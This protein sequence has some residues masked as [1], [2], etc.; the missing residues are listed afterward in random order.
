MRQIS[1]GKI[2]L[3][4]WLPFLYAAFVFLSDM[5]DKL[6]K[7]LNKQSIR[8]LLFGIGEAVVG[9]IVYYINVKRT[10]KEYQSIKQRFK[11]KKNVIS[12]IQSIPH[13]KNKLI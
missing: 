6:S 3:K 13:Y 10:R 9:S 5:T 2:C 11:F 4:Y 12:P 8:L 1:M 7:E